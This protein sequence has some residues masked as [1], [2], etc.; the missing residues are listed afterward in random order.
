MEID[1]ITNKSDKVRNVLNSDLGVLIGS[2][3]YEKQSSFLKCS[4]AYLSIIKNGLREPNLKQGRPTK[5]LSESEQ[6]V[7]E[8]LEEQ[9]TNDCFPT[10][11]EFKEVCVSFLEEQNFQGSWSKNYFNT[12]LN[13]IA[14]DFETRVT[15]ALDYERGDLKEEDLQNY[16]KILKD[17]LIEKINPKLIIN[18]DETGFG[19]SKS[20]KKRGKKVL[21]RKNYKGNC[22]YQADKQVNLISALV[23]VTAFGEMIPPCCIVQRGSEHP[24]SAKCPFY[25]KMKVYATP[26]SFITRSVFENYLNEY[27]F[28][29]IEKVRD[30]IG[31]ENAPAIIIYDGHKSHLSH[32]LFAKCA[33]KNINV[34]IIPPH[35]SHLVQTLDQGI[36]RS[37]KNDYSSVP[38]WPDVSKISQRLQKIFTVLE[39]AQNHQLIL[40]SWAKVGILPILVDGD[41]DHV[42][43]VEN[44]VLKNESVLNALSK[45][46]NEK[47]RGKK[48]DRADWGL[49]NEDEIKRVKD[50]LCPLCGLKLSQ[51]ESE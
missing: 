11:K 50:G 25:N 37:M 34:V 1:K 28:N 40:R 13:R 47:E 10:K 38:D 51:D 19:G 39:R 12:L 27:V 15:Q 29:Y 14:P 21:V 17:L 22:F 23:A 41:V 48:N 6:K 24:D 35:S 5:L 8:W 32:I 9:S 36:F 49:M 3:P 26:N 4:K 31:D 45:K 2:L 16:F 44:A 33:E 18:L 42:E 30:E 46:V 43:L 20:V 7:R